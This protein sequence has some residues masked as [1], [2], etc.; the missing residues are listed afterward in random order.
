MA[1]RYWTLRCFRQGN[2]ESDK[3]R[4]SYRPGNILTFS[5]STTYIAIMIAL[6]SRI[7]AE[8]ATIMPLE[9]APLVIGLTWLEAA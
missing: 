4:A 1:P 9:V 7:P 6:M 2:T 3:Q 5:T 8:P